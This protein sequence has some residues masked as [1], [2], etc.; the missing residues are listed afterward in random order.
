MGTVNLCDQFQW[1]GIPTRCSDNC[2]LQ[3]SQQK[4]E[5]TRGEE[6]NEA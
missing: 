3:D 1:D 2:K 4:I 5:S 6:W